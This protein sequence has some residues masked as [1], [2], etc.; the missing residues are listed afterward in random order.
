[1]SRTPDEARR[2]ELLDRAVDYVC[3]QG[4]ADLSLRPLAKAV[5]SSPRVLLYYF[6]SKENLVVE[7]IGRGRARQR[8]M[9]AQLKLTDFSPRANLAYALARVEQAR[10]GA[11]DATLLRG[12][13]TCAAGSLAL[14]RLSRKRNQRMADGAGGLHA[15][16]GL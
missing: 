6:G 4:L 10:V 13:R 12:L 14:P 11:A 15:A 2:A 5:G 8:A 7:I 1:M 16:A 9:M 3:R